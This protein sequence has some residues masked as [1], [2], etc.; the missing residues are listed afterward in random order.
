MQKRTKRSY[1]LSLSNYF[2]GLSYFLRPNY[3]LIAI[4]K[5]FPVE[6]TESTEST[7]ES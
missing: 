2:L 1:Y 4:K 7:V 6:S 3:T 5:Q